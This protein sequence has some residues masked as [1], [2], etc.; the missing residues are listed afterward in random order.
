[1]QAEEEVRLLQQQ[2]EQLTSKLEARHKQQIQVLAAL[3]VLQIA[4]GCWP[5]WLSSLTSCPLTVRRH[6]RVHHI[7]LTGWGSQHH[8]VSWHLS[9]SAWKQPAPDRLCCP[10]QE[11]R[12]QFQA[13]VDD[14]TQQQASLIKRLKEQ[15][16]AERERV[17]R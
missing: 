14:T 6:G 12:A 9:M 8:C 7:I 5:A 16:A 3:A 15:H 4:F 17:Q 1:M 2:H 11:L 13:M 10:S